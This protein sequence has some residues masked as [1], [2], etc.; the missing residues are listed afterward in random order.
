MIIF[1]CGIIN[2]Y[3]YIIGV[4]IFFIIDDET[5]LEKLV[6]FSRPHSW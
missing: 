2:L 6:I 4:I 5:S 3:F 1:H